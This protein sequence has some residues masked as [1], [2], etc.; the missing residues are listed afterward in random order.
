[1]EIYAGFSRVPITP[2]KPMRM[3]GFDKRTQLSEGVHDELYVSCLVLKTQDGSVAVLSLD[4]LGVDESLSGAIR[5]RIQEYDGQ[6]GKCEVFVC[7]THNHSGPSGIFSG[8]DSYDA[9]YVNYL[10]RQ[11]AESFRK[12]MD[13]LEPSRITGGTVAVP[14]IASRRNNP[15]DR[16]ALSC[17][18]LGIENR[19]GKIRV[20]NYP[21][22]MTVLNEDNRFFSR[23]MLLGVQEEFSRCGISALLYINGAAG[24]ISARFYKKESSFEE[25]QRLG[26]MLAQNVRRAE[27]N[28]SFRWQPSP[29]QCK[30]ASFSAVYCQPLT[31]DEKL[32]RRNRIEEVLCRVGDPRRCRD[33]QSALLVLARPNRKPETIPGAVTA[34]GRVTKN[35]EIRLAIS[36]NLALISIPFEIYYDTG[37][38]IKRILIQK[39]PGVR[40]LLAGYCG[41]YNGYIPP[42]DVFGSISYE[43]EAAL[44]EPDTE[45]RLLETVE[46]L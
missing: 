14:D 2:A 31:A 44:F 21:C 6:I 8:R 4:I 43:T 41:G 11:S 37:I 23:D 38:R 46:N 45:S 19:R 36:G 27:E 33:L 15:A 1:M 22:H 32:A 12:A 39:Y 5:A 10:V 42:A 26:R 35:V 3:A 34:E 29:W 24:D 28:A 16:M 20:V 30:A 17:G 9:A 25:A 13:S 18:W 40:V 7:A